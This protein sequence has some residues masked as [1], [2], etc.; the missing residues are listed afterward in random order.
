M[1]SRSPNWGPLLGLAPGRIDEFMWMYAF[2]LED[3]TPVQAYK[4]RWTR[5]YLYLNDGGRAF[6]PTGRSAFV[7]TDPQ[8]MLAAAVDDRP[9][10]SAD[11]DIVRHNYFSFTWAR[12]TTKHGISRDRARFVVENSK[13]HI[14]QDPPGSTVHSD[15]RLVFLGD[16][17][18]GVPLEVIA[19]VASQGLRVIHAMGL[20]NPFRHTYEEMKRWPR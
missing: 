4:H 18:G 11:L 20:R 9:E 2:E 1:P 7:E 14:S 19:I 10:P 16:D 17:E 8:A 6:V 3:G 15:Q 13:C 12:S 5:R